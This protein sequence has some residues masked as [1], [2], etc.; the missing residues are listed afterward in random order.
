MKNLFST[1]V[2]GP[3]VVGMAEPK[4]YGFQPAYTPIMEGI[5]DL[6]HYICFFLVVI[7]VFVSWMLFFTIYI[8]RYQVQLAVHNS[9]DSFLEAYKKD[10]KAS[11]PQLYAIRERIA[12]L[13]FF[14]AKPVDYKKTRRLSHC[15]ALEVG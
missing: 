11:Y 10:L 9:A 6:H 7:L 5:I 14:I 1:L 8:Y 12:S 3:M 15:T 4:Q 2:E 13:F